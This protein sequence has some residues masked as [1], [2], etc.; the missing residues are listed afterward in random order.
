MVA[1]TISAIAAYYSIVG[2]TAI[3]AAAVIPIILMG[4]ALEIG[5]IF[6]TIWLHHN[7]H[8]TPKSLKIYL[9][10]AVIVL[11]FITSMG[12]FGF[13][14]RAHIEQASA[15]T[16]ASARIETIEGEIARQQATIARAEEKIED[17]ETGASGA[18]AALQAQIDREQSRIDQAYERIQP[19]ID[20]LQEEIAAERERIAQEIE[21][22]RGRL[23]QLDDHI[24]NGQI[25]EAQILVGAVPDGDFGPGTA[26]AVQAWRE[27]LE[28][29]IIRMRD[30]PTPAIEA[31]RAEVQRLRD[32]AEASIAE[33]NALITRLQSQLGTSTREDADDEIAAENARITEANALID[34]LTSEKFELEA[35]FRALE[36]EVGPVK[37]IAEM[38]YAE[39]DRDVLEDAVR[40]VIIIIVAVF[41]PLAVMLVLAGTMT[42]EWA[43]KERAR[44]R[45][46]SD[47]SDLEELQRYIKELEDKQLVDEEIQALIEE[48]KRT[49][50]EIIANK[51]REIELLE[52]Q[53]LEEGVH[54]LVYRDVE[55]PV[56]IPVNA[57]QVS[58]LEARVAELEEDDLIKYNQAKAYLDKI[59]ALEKE[60]KDANMKLEE[61]LVIME[62]LDAALERKPTEVEKIVEDTTRIDELEAERAVLAERIVELTGAVEEQHKQKENAI[63]RLRQNLESAHADKVRLENDI[64]ARDKAVQAINE[65][66]DLVAKVPGISLQ[67]DNTATAGGSTA[68]G[69]TFPDTPV[70]DQLFLR[71]DTTPSKLYRFDGSRWLEEHDRTAVKYDERYLEH[72]ISEVSAGSVELEDLSEQEQ[73]S[74]REILSKED[75]L[76]R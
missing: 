25:Q 21:I 22:K 8:R 68:F 61:Y 24:A 40:W 48:V 36:A 56:E 41:D 9:T 31:A 74:I 70:K 19:Q 6:T 16:E 17:L 29:E 34:T 75:V 11:M 69:T 50:E 13:L 73:N 53:A 44:R 2:L 64:E 54:H 57:E 67:P 42:I 37:F 10:S 18:D 26:R 15:G 46:E 39:A 65:K 4:G 20:R 71:V 32:Q 55:V 51:N 1:V 72:L 30:T 47:Q 60:L 14:S 33:S 38:I 66:Y 28:A 49:Y 5:K 52:E 7:W 63:T 45:E 59:A 76:G 58:Q 3:F 35:Q 43:Q 62:E 27:G 23:A 12:V